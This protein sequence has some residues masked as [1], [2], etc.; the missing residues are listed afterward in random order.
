M[1]QLYWLNN[2]KRVA[3]ANMK[4]LCSHMQRLSNPKVTHVRLNNL[5]RECITGCG[6]CAI[7]CRSYGS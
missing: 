6:G 4:G 2:L 7:I 1:S 3:V 5:K